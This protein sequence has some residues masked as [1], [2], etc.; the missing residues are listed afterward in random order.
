MMRSMIDS[1]CSHHTVGVPRLHSGELGKAKKFGSLGIENVAA[2]LGTWFCGVE[3][4]YLILPF[5]TVRGRQ[6]NHGIT[7]ALREPSRTLL[8]CTY[9]RES[10]WG[11]GAS[12]VG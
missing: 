4:F 5:S 7:A 10:Q 2:Y 6:S 1:R 9:R 12:M 8:Y 11:I 3:L